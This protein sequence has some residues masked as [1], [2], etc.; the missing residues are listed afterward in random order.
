M[1]KW[2]KK[3]QI[4]ITKS[5]LYTM[6]KSAIKDVIHEERIDLILKGIPEVSPE[7]MKDIEKLYG[8]PKKRKPVR[9]VTLDI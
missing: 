3:M 1:I 8:K 7:E 5:E 9:R 2:S 6:I 4:S